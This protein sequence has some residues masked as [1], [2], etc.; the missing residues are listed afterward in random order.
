MSI[1]FRPVKDFETRSKVTLRKN[2]SALDVEVFSRDDWRCHYCG[3][4]HALTID[5]IVP[6]VSGGTD[7]PINLVAACRSCNSSKRTKGYEEFKEWLS[8]EM[9]AYE[10]M[11]SFGGE[12]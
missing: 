3:S 8:A 7:D 11:V 6:K 10:T 9:A 4:P 5:H 1:S 2:L 12:V